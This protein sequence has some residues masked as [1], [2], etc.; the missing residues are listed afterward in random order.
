MSGVVRAAAAGIVI[1]CALSWSWTLEV[2]NEEAHTS[3]PP[4][5]R[6]TPATTMPVQE[7]SLSNELRMVVSLVR[8]WALR[9]VGP[10]LFSCNHNVL[11]RVVVNDARRCL[12][13]HT[14]A[15]GA[16]RRRRPSEVAGRPVGDL[17]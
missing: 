2:A 14:P 8:P 7:M 9:V 5:T 11:L 16:R 1:C 15:G 3:R 12:V 4:A 6:R 10:L 17:G 13:R